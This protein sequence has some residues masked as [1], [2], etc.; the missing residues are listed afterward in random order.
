MMISSWKNKEVAKKR[1]INNVEVV[2][3]VWI[4]FF[5][6]SFSWTSIEAYVVCTSVAKLQIYS[7]MHASSQSSFSP[8]H[9]ELSTK[10][11]LR[12]RLDCA[13]G[14]YEEAEWIYIE[15]GTWSFS[16]R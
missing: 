15:K 5:L 8:G 6:Q 11:L 12:G 10:M 3:S 9:V 13:A 4:I 2:L 16:W 7:H 1:F 14:T